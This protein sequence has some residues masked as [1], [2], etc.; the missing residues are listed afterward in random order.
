MDER[1][2]ERTGIYFDI[3]FDSDSISIEIDEKS[4]YL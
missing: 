3:V 4:F 2:F 1:A